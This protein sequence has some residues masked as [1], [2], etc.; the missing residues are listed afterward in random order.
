MDKQ[1]VHDAIVRLRFMADLTP[2]VRSRVAG[3]LEQI[4]K[5]RKVPRDAVW[6]KE[7]EHSPNKGYILVRG[8]AAIQ[9][10]DFPQVD[11]QAPELLGEMMQFNPGSLRTATVFSTE[12]SVV[13]RF[14][15]DEFWAA[16][17]EQLS[18]KDREAVRTAI[19]SQAWEHFAQ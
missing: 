10:T 7:N 18:K 17:E 8:A 14:M 11:C 4:G 13:M 6:I 1:D 3:I 5:L 12:E 9:K 16:L 19:E 15:W 2:E